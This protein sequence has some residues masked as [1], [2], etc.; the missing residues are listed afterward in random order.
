MA[1]DVLAVLGETRETGQAVIASTL[2]K[3]RSMRA[4]CRPGSEP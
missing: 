1:L 4:L 3:G 2:G